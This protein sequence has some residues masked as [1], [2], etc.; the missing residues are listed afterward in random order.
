MFP[1]P[2]RYCRE[3]PGA[4]VPGNSGPMTKTLDLAPMG[5]ENDQ[6][7]SR[8]CPACQWVV[9]THFRA[10]AA[11]GL[12][13]RKGFHCM[14]HLM[15]CSISVISHPNSITRR[16][17]VNQRCVSMCVLIGTNGTYIIGCHVAMAS[18]SQNLFW[19]LFERSYRGNPHS[20]LRRSY[21]LRYSL[22]GF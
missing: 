3:Q 21:D 13:T 6:S 17:K 19:S 7:V 15:P 10:E 20:D 8:S 9:R 5:Q 16:R 18:V 12:T 14:L 2:D 22:R 11:E 4:S 1:S